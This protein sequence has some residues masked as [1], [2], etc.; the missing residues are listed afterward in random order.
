MCWFN[1]FF[2]GFQWFWN[3][4]ES[5]LGDFFGEGGVS[6]LYRPLSVLTHKFHTMCGLNHFFWDDSLV[7]TRYPFHFRI[8]SGQ[9]GRGEGFTYS[10]TALGLIK[11]TL[12]TFGKSDPL[13]RP[14]I[15]MAKIQLLFF[16]SLI[17]TFLLFLF[18]LTF[19]V[20]CLD[21]PE[22]GR[23]HDGCSYP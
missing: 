23:S 9:F 16:S 18:L 22:R 5:R 12:K 6:S 13:M 20:F 7:L 21:F 2:L 11:I 10:E 8:T 17:L 14:S 15:C 19:V 1:H 4:T 3:C